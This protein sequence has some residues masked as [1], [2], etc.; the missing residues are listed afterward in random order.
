M[1]RVRTGR[2]ML[3]RSPVPMTGKRRSLHREEIEEQERQPEV[4]HRHPDKGDGADEKIGQLIPLD[5]RHRPQRQR[6]RCRQE[7]SRPG[8]GEGIGELAGQL[9]ED[10]LLK[11]VGGPEVAVEDVPEPVPV[12]D[13]QRLVQPHLCPRL[14]QQLRAG[15]NPPG[16]VVHLRPVAGASEVY[17]YLLKVTPKKTKRKEIHRARIKYRFQSPRSR[18]ARSFIIKSLPEIKNKK[19]AIPAFLTGTAAFWSA[20]TKRYTFA[21]FPGFGRRMGTSAPGFIQSAK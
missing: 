9:G 4:R 3:L 1:T 15:G 14:R 19:A 10:A 16:E 12:L 2:A 6:N 5:R 11:V 21:A 18:A 17:V 20:N 13:K 8:E 7:E